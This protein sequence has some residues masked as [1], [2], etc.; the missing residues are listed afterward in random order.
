[1]VTSQDVSHDKFANR[2]DA[3]AIEQH[4]KDHPRDPHHLEQVVDYETVG[5]Q[6]NVKLPFEFVYG[7]GGGLEAGSA[8]WHLSILKTQAGWK[9]NPAGEEAAAAP[10]YFPGTPLLSGET[11]NR[12]APRLKSWSFYPSQY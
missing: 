8:Y 1:M 5:E 10:R 11:L 3:D 2:S 7:H 12:L 6:G 9:I 4:K